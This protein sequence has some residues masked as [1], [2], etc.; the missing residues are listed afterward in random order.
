MV[1]LDCRL[2]G[3]CAGNLGGFRD[4]GAG[5][6][7]SQGVFSIFFKDLGGFRGLQRCKVFMLDSRAYM[8]SV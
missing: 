7:R 8:A 3:L 5:Y 2:F 1:V 4:S 6:S